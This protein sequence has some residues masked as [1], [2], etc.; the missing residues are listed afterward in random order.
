MTL[1]SVRVPARE[2]LTGLGG[3]ELINRVLLGRKVIGAGEY[4]YGVVWI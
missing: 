1:E 4:G 2:T 3:R